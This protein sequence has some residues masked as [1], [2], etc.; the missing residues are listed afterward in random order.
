MMAWP[1]IICG[2]LLTAIGAYGYLN[3]TP[4]ADGSVS[5]TALIPAALGLVLMLC[6]SLAFEAKRRKHVM[7]FA[8]VVG[9]LGILG[10][11]APLI[12]QAAGGKDLDPLAP[13]ALAGL[14]MSA[15]SA[16]FVGLCVKSFVDARKARQAAAG[17]AG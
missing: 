2:A 5:P 15:V 11:F 16:V 3:A 8:A 12:R 1:T 6:G 13:S 4:K 14:A 17:V 9:V 7:H 10:G